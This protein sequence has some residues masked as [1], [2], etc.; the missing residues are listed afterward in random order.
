MSET[1]IVFLGVAVFAA[2]FGF[3]FWKM[4][5]PSRRLYKLLGDGSRAGLR[6]IRP[7]MPEWSYLPHHLAPFLGESGKDYKPGLA[8]QFAGGEGYLLSIV[9]IVKLIRKK[10]YRRGEVVVRRV[11]TGLD[12]PF[13]LHLRK[14]PGQLPGVA[15]KLLAGLLP[16]EAGLSQFLPEMRESF[17]A[18]GERAALPEPVQRTLVTALDPN[19]FDLAKR[20]ANTSGLRFYP[21]GIRFPISYYKRP[22]SV[23]DVRRILDFVEELARGFR[24]Q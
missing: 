20:L 24:F 15:K 1:A 5:Q 23:A 18:Y 10:E 11:A 8:Y 6:L 21:E 17:V 22:K 14:A 2:G 9:E 4:T 16:K 19:G 13:T 7:E 12:S 3:L